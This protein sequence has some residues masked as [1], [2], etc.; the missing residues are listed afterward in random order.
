M[1]FVK[2]DW[3]ANQP[4]ATR[5]SIADSLLAWLSLTCFAVGQHDIDWP[6]RIFGSTRHRNEQQLCFFEEPARRTSCG[7]FNHEAITSR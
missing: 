2:A 4:A 6:G 5:H 1:A 7:R 3:G